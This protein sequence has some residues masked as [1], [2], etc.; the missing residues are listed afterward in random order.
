M[1]ASI[2]RIASGTVCSVIVIIAIVVSN[3]KI[4]TTEQGLVI[5][6]GA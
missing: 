6:G 3:D 2:K 5:I 1:M 4:R